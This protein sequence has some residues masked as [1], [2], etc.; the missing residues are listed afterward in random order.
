MGWQEEYKR[1]VVSAEEAV[2]VVKSGDRVVFSHGCEPPELVD[3]LVK[4][5]DELKDVTIFMLMPRRDADW[6]HP[7]WEESFRIE[8]GIVM[9]AIL[10]LMKEG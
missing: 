2:R 3:A 1:K 10:D 6:Y 7:G 9:P 4:R 8:A 5:K